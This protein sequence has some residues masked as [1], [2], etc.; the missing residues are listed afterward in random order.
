MLT[1]CGPC[2]LLGAPDHLFHNN[3][4]GTFTDVS[5]RAHVADKPGYYGLVSLF[6]DLDGDGLPE[7]LV[8]NDSTPNY[9]Y[10][11][12]G[13][14]TFQDQ[15]FESGFAVNGEGR[16][17]ATMGVAAADFKNTGQLGLSTTN[18]SD[19]YK[20]VYDGDGKLGFSDVSL[21]VGVGEVSTPF[22]GWSVGFIDFDGDGWRDLFFASGHV[23]PQVDQQPWGT[24]FAQC[25]LLFRNTIGAGVIISSG[26]L[27]QRGDVLCGGSFA[28]SN[29]PRLFFG[30]GNSSKVD[31][32]EITWPDHSSQS[33]HDLASDHI[34][35]I[36]EADGTVRIQ[37]SSR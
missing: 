35:L 19:D 3:G 9:L 28:S 31:S 14:G 27:H 21:K 26:D 34:Y 37:P 10:R 24:S 15:S 2:G 16:E 25:P 1:F 5:E 6:V 20:L 12:L 23:Y 4:N 11:N 22:L 8:G 17:T 7:L 33:L 29:D 13:D 18:F 30:L 32:V 36:S